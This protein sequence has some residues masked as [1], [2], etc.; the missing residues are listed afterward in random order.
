MT[1]GTPSGGD[2]IVY[3][4]KEILADI[5]DKLTRQAQLAEQIERRVSALENRVDSHD[6]V[7][8]DMVPQLKDFV[9]K[10][11]IQ[12]AVEDAMESKKVGIANYDRVMIGALSVAVVFLSLILPHLFG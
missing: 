9:E 7:L 4:T 3:T 8:M 1:G 6:K 5:N 11:N 10:I 12:K 2:R